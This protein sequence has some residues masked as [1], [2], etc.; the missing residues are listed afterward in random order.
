MLVHFLCN[1]VYYRSLYFFF[2]QPKNADLKCVYP[3]PDESCV[4]KFGMNWK[5]SCPCNFPT[6]I[7]S[8][9]ITKFISIH[10]IQAISS[11]SI[12]RRPVD[13]YRV[14]REG[15]YKIYV[16]QSITWCV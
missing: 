2:N 10:A 7:S 16:Q 5:Q 4:M 15:K 3:L 11:S 6:L 8:A 13:S 14:N 1:D 9:P 12:F